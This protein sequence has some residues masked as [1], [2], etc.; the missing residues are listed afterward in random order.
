MTK[1]TVAFSILPKIAA[2]F[3]HMFLCD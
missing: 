3:S 2:F 1:I